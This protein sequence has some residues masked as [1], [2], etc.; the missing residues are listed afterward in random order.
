MSQQRLFPFRQVAVDNMIRGVTRVWWQLESAF[1]DPG[2]RVFQLQFGN[3]GLRDSPDWHNVG[4]PVTDGYVAYDDA[5]RNSASDLLTH[6]RVTLTTA[7]NIYVSQAVNCFGELA[8]R[9]WVLAREVVRKEQLR[10]KYVSASGFLLK[11]YRFG[12]PCKRCR[13]ELTGEVLDS[14]CPI[15]NGTSFE[16]GYHPPLALQCWDLSPQTINEQ[17]DNEV[18]GTTR[19]PT[20]VT[21]RVIG[22]PTINR[23]DI[24]INGASDERW[25]VQKIQ[26]A[27]AMRGVP[28][29]YNIQMAL[30]PFSSPI[31]EIEVGGEPPERP[32]PTPPQI[33]CGIVPV[34]HNFNAPDYLAYVD[35]TG[36]TVS[37]AKVYVFPKDIYDAAQPD[38]PA[39]T[40]AIAHTTTGANG[41]WADALLL[42]PGNYAVLFEKPGEYG[43]NAQLITVVG[44]GQPTVFWET[45]ILGDSSEA[46][47]TERS[48]GVETEQQ[49]PGPFPPPDDFW[50][51]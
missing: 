8:E 50:N 2:P 45:E 35:A 24:W 11:P 1:N 28:L 32:G 7:E 36:Y 29:V 16:V 6:Y 13:D 42:N 44:A 19:E 3:T 34:D 14:N 30:I 5:W 33:G 22:F 39:R 25:L 15:C 10:H 51:F 43:P 37:G 31:Y 20:P 46:V 38:Y 23:N 9:D 27:A 41:R 47:L 17:Q 21:A 12:R 40:A 26:V 4:S 49:L 18:K 48:E